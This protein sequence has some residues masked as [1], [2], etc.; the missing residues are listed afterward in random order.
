LSGWTAIRLH[1]TFRSELERLYTIPS[2]NLPDYRSDA[3]YGVAQTEEASTVPATFIAVLA[4]WGDS[5]TDEWW[6]DELQRFSQ[7]PHDATGAK[8]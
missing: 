3:E 5:K 2:L 4:Y 6:L 1:D 7:W 8:K